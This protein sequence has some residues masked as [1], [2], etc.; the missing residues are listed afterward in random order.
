MIPNPPN[1][2]T[3][4]PKPQPPPRPLLGPR[5]L[6]PHLALLAASWASSCGASM[7]L[8]SGS[9]PWRRDFA[10]AGAKLSRALDGVAPEAFVAAVDRAGRA[11]L[12]EFMAGVLAYR[13]HTRPPRP[14]E[15]PTIWREGAFRLLD[16]GA[17]LPRGA[18]AVLVVPSLINRAYVLDL[19]SEHSFLRYLAA[20]GIRPFLV[21]WGAPGPDERGFTLT[22]YIAGPLEQALEIAADASR[23]RPGVIGY[24][25]GGLLA[26]SLAQRRSDL[27]AHLVLLAT[28]WDFHADRRIADL[29]PFSKMALRLGIEAADGMPVDSLQLMFNA[30][31]PWATARKF[32]AFGRRAA[33]APA[34]DPRLTAFIALEDWLNDG[35]DLA[36]AVARE[37]LIGWYAE[38]SPPNGRWRVAGRP[39]DPRSL[40]CP[41]LAIVPRQDRIVPPEAAL[42]LADAIGGC[43]TLTPAMGHIGM[44]TAR[45]APEKVWAPIAHWCRSQSGLAA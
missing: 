23:V 9:L 24:C 40:V 27:V 38:N 41:T 34:D 3:Q 16:Y 15:P 43:V 33:T 5:P 4:R 30:I 28:P 21:D 39:V 44:V 19:L 22:D 26:L 7:L 45:A 35:T 17:D 14:V 12:G 37:C 6:P 18:P 42:P 25:M 31:D 10:E 2:A 29:A 36:R 1:N 13:R 11:R 32:I 20:S 8:S